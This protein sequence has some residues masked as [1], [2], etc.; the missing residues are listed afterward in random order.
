MAGTR[1]WR[2]HLTGPDPEPREQAEVAAPSGPPPT[3]IEPGCEIEGNFALDGPL[4]VEGEFRGAIECGAS[5]T[6]SEHGSVEA[7]I[8]GREVN[9]HGAVVGDITA[10]REVVLHPTARVHGN[11]TAPSVVIERGAFF[12]G[13]TRMF[14]PERRILDECSDA[15]TPAIAPEG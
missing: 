14:R 7:G 6:V 13:E 15:V 9:I 2:R 5:V 3:R 4:V 1:G 8:E 11:L 12:Q 10:R